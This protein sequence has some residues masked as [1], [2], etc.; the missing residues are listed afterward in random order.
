MFVL[1]DSS[2]AQE[3]SGEEQVEDEQEPEG[4]DL[5]SDVRV[6]LF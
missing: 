3:A 1:F 6:L 5:R 2:E 4:E